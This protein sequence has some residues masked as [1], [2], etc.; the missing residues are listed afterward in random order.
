MSLRFNSNIKS[1]QNIC[2]SSSTVSLVCLSNCLTSQLGF[3]CYVQLTDCTENSETPCCA[4]LQPAIPPLQVIHLQPRHSLCGPGHPT[5]PLISLV[6]HHC[7]VL[8]LCGPGESSPLWAEGGSGALEAC[9][10]P[11]APVKGPVHHAD[12]LLSLQPT[13]RLRLVGNG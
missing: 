10:G 7:L 2:P 1:E 5:R 6:E 12:V 13:V 9:T 8:G 4:W 11:P 3:G